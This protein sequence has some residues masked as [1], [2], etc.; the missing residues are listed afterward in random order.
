MILSPDSAR[1]LLES[2]EFM[3]RR[4]VQEYEKHDGRTF[5]EILFDVKEELREEYIALVHSLNMPDNGV[6][7]PREK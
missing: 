7:V 5:D 4:I 1:K 3:A 2:H 6:H